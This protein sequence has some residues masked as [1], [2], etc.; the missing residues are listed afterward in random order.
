M[1]I[2]QG[3][4]RATS[5]TRSVLRRRDFRLYLL[6]FTT[7]QLG[8]FLYLVALVAYVFDRTGSATWVAAATLS[9]F[10]PY[11]LLS[12]LAGIVAD[13]FE[14][15][16][17]M[18]VSDA[19]QL[20]A[21][22]ALTIAAAVSGPALLVVVL[23]G[24]SASAATLYQASASALVTA[25][26]PEDELASANSLVSTVSEV[27]FVTGPA[28]GGLL[29]LL[30]D[31]AVAF[32]INAATFAVSAVLLLAIRSRS[33]RRGGGDDGDRAGVLVQLR[34]GAAALFG[35][36]LVLVLVT[37]LV[38][39]SVVY[40]VEL[41]VLVLVSDE[42]LGT[43]TGGLGWLL[44]A[45]GV[46]GV[47]GA[48]L[49]ARLA[50]SGRPRAVIGVL[51]LLTGIPLATLAVL[52]APPLAYAVLVVEGIA[53][54]ALDV[55]VE[56]AMQRSVPG[57]V[58]GRV[59]GLVLSL[60]AVGTAAGTFL[61]PV[62]VSLLGLPG[63]LAIGGLVPVVLAAASLLFV[64][65]LDAA[66]AR[67]RRALAPRVAVLEGLRLLDGAGQAALERLAATVEEERAPAGTAVLRQGDPADD[68]LVLVE[69][70]LVVHHDDG[71]GPRRVNEMVAPDYLGE[72]G[73]VERV[74]RTA[75]VTAQTDALLWRIPGALFLDAVGRGP[76]LSPSLATGIST[77]LAR[78]PLRTG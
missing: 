27:A 3:R 4:H 60:T 41:V 66:A 19:V 1:I 38:A 18:A 53:I 61:A 54:V 34:E 23:S 37:C 39:G 56:T 10:V 21:M 47:L 25:L 20:S 31:P 35:D 76:A 62:L 15:H 49:S 75:T 29:L 28:A 58:L 59:S 70:A 14:R 44:A 11:T 30:G 48:T 8:D 65:D 51:V 78:T 71:T 40:G 57:D 67:G 36:R 63:T 68:L 42:L 24:A 52:R 5:P 9:R 26:V 2:G 72:I 33:A 12:P 17:V 43:G 32:G 50:R 55:L 46:G 73:L 16:R 7:S 77:R 22:V 13:R 74:P 6:S 45:S 69:G 64:G